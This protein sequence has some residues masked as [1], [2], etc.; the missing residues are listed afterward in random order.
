MAQP[1]PVISGFS[2]VFHLLV[3]IARKIVLLGKK[4]LR[5]K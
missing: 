3:L 4:V 1:F 2:L 5:K